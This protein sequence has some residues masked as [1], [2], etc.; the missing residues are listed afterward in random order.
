MQG[1]E[2]LA[3]LRSSEWLLRMRV[4]YQKRIICQLLKVPRYFQWNGIL[5][6]PATR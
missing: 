1:G 5:S 2:L 6:L 4:S 3:L